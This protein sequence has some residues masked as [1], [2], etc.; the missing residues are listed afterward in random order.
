MAPRHFESAVRQ[1]MISVAIDQQERLVA[2]R[3]HP[4]HKVDRDG[5][6]G[7]QDQLLPNRDNRIQHRPRR[8]RQ[9]TGPLQDLRIPSAAPASQKLQTVGLIRWFFDTCHPHGHQMQHPGGL[10]GV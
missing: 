8:I 4:G 7:S 5:R 2:G 3:R 9:P 6:V 1:V 10:L